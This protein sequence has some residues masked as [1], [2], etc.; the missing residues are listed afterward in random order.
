MEIKPES[1]I[2]G[3]SPALDRTGRPWPRKFLVLFSTRS[4]K[5]SETSSKERKPIM[6]LI[7]RLRITMIIIIST[8]TICLVYVV[9]IVVNANLA[10]PTLITELM[11]SDQLT[12]KPEELPDDY[13]KALI[14]VEDPNFYA[15]NG[16]DVTTPG[17]GWTTITQGIVK[18][19]FFDGFTPGFAR[20]NKVKQ[21]LIALVFNRQ[22]D[23]HTQ[24]R[25]FI[26]AVYLG[27]VAEQE[28]IG[29]TEGAQVYFNKEF[30]QLSKEEYLALIATIIA[31]NQFNVRTKA[32]ANQG[33]VRR[34][35]QLLN[36]DCKPT[37]VTD[38]YYEHCR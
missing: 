17:A 27:T 28:V 38:V 15:H 16:I 32:A 2:T 14:T 22:V 29:L 35:K 33:R 13:L 25:I 23:K 10:I 9:F 37:S 4:L 31:P 12:L 19:Y 30:A 36:G 5:H 21:S 8:A 1:W 18:I 24:L 20:I 26:N 3:V 34:I 6:A 7:K 11:S